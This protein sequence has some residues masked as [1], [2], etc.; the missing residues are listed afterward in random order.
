MPGLDERNWYWLFDKIEFSDTDS[1]SWVNTEGGRSYPSRDLFNILNMKHYSV[2]MKANTPSLIQQLARKINLVKLLN[3]EC[4]Q[5]CGRNICTRRNPLFIFAF[6]EH[7][8]NYGSAPLHWWRRLPWYKWIT[9]HHRHPTWKYPPQM[10][11]KM[12]LRYFK[13]VSAKLSTVGASIRKLRIGK[14]FG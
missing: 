12:T 2:V 3:L 6:V 10:Q 14:L 8:L 5:S 11:G 13:M 7:F 9:E 1:R 4:M